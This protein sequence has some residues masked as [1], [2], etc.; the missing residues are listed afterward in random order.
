[1]TIYFCQSTVL[2]F[3][4]EK[5]EKKKSLFKCSLESSEEAYE[6]LVLMEKSDKKG[7]V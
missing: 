4:I 3:F 2:F 7:R 5:R 6:Q 1:M